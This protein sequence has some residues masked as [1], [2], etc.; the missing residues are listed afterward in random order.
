MPIE[1]PTS[2]LH[3]LRAGLGRSFGVPESVV[4]TG[5]LL[6]FSG[7][8]GV[9]CVTRGHRSFTE[10]TRP[11]QAQ[12]ARSNLLLT[13]VGGAIVNFSVKALLVSES[14]HMTGY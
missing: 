1:P 9:T 6:L 4:V 13:L 7:W 5:L 10:V 2:A 3:G 11:V 8:A 14:G 12:A